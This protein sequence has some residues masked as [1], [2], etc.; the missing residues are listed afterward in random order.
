MYCDQNKMIMGKVKITTWVVIATP[1]NIWTFS[2]ATIR[3]RNNEKVELSK[4]KSWSVIPKNVQQ[5]EKN[6]FSSSQQINEDI[7]INVMVSE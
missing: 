5:F 4:I 3:L 7:K 2:S 6:P 1:N